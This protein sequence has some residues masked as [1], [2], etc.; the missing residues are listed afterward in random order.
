MMMDLRCCGE[1]NP[2]GVD[3]QNIRLSFTLS[4]SLEIKNYEINIWETVT[5]K[6]VWH[7]ENSVTESL[8]CWVDPACLQAQNTIATFHNMNKVIDI[9]TKQNVQENFF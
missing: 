2:I 5:E 4:G 9:T 6:Q 8:I 1:K 7:E 3:K